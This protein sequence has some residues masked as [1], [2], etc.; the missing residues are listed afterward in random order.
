SFLTGLYGHKNGIVNNHTPFP[1]NNVTWATL[2]RRLGYVT[3][4]IGKWHMDQ[5]K[6]QRPGFAFSASFIGQGKYFDCP[7][8]VNGELT[9]TRGW[10]DDVSTDFALRFL[11]EHKDGPFALAIGFKATHGPFQPP[12]RFK[13]HYDGEQPRP[14]P[15][16]T[17]PA[18][19]RPVGA[20]AAAKKK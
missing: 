18:I 4:Y 5:Q 13:D 20:A 7:V 14:V 16:L 19:Y 10:V 2:L 9:Q 15:N 8:E 1:V 3:G 6:G 17:T 11:R 12:E